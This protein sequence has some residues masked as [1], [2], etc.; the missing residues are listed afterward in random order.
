MLTQ[1][2]ATEAQEH[3]VVGKTSFNVRDI[4]NH[5]FR[6]SPFRTVA[7]LVGDIVGSPSGFGAAVFLVL[8]WMLSGPIFHFSDRW[9]LIMNTVTNV[10]TFLMVFLLQTTQNR[11]MS[12]LQI[13]LDELLRITPGARP[14]VIAVETTPNDE[15]EK[16]EQEFVAMSH[17]VSRMAYAIIQVRVYDQQKFADYIQGHMPILEK[18]GGRI[19]VARTPEIVPEGTWSPQTVVVQTWPDVN[20]FW[21]FYESPEYQP[22]KELRHRSAETDIVVVEAN[23]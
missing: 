17:S 22:W 7:H 8:V 1:E 18:Y 5:R 10:V 19:V 23:G 11:D 9:Q 15:V 14:A 16:F 4:V 20:A 13:K 6:R 21:R 3:L 2:A 12:A